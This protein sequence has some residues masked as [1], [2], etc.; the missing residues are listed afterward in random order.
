M[1]RITQE[2][3]FLS[4]LLAQVRAGRLV[5]AAFQRPYRWAV[6]DVED[7]W[8][9]IADQ[10]PVG[11]FLIWRP[12]A[13]LPIERLARTRLGP[14]AVDLGGRPGLILDGQNRLA[15]YA[16]SMLRPDDPRPDPDAVSPEERAAWYGDRVL[17]ADSRE[18]RVGFVAR[19]EAE[20]LH[21]YPPGIVGDIPLLNRTLRARIAAG[22]AL[23][24]PGIDWLDG[25][26]EKLRTTRTVVTTL[27]EATPEEAFRHFRRINRAGVPMSDA[28]LARTLGLAEAMLQSLT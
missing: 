16:W 20:G 25:L 15:T 13:A 27:E 12:P 5:P 8:A 9:S 26:G 2:T 23:D 6:D 14:I 7:L 24:D 19:A 11:L 3:G 1:S 18:R 28:D 17:T 22:A 21:H 4:D 10:C